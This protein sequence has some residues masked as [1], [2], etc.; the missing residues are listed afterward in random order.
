MRQGSSR[1]PGGAVDCHVHVFD[2]ARFPF[3]ATRSYTPGQA[4]VADLRSMMV[5]LGMERTV[6]VQPSVYGTDN[7]C[8]LDAVRQLGPD[9]ARGIAV[10]DPAVVTDAELD[11][12]SAAGVVGLRINLA[13]RA[14][15]RGAA[16]ID[17]VARLTSRIAGTGL[18]MQIFAGM[19]LLEALEPILTEMPIPVVLDHF[20]GARAAA[21]SGQPGF[22]AL[23]RLL[24]DGKVWVKLSAPYRA[25]DQAPAYADLQPMVEAMVSANPDRLLWASDWPHTGGGD[26][27]DRNPAGIEPFRAVDSARF[28]QELTAWVPDPAIRQKVLV[29][30]AAAVFRF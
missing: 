14:E 2:G 16:A 25:S 18:L 17:A 28:L 22:A 21:G 8:L 27:G 12:L 11:A 1:I 9:V 20:A 29:G 26:R 6:L 5:T 15:D 30:N 13:V 10:V 24:G 3:A 7:R 4:T 23:M 19:P